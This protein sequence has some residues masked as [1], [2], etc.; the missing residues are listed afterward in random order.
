[1]QGGRCLA[2][3]GAPFGIKPGSPTASVCHVSGCKPAPLIHGTSKE[4]WGQLGLKKV[5][6]SSG[7]R[8]R[9]A[10]HAQERLLHSNAATQR[11]VC[12]LFL[13]ADLPPSPI[14]YPRRCVHSGALR[15]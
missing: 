11:P 7:C 3:A 5:T 13:G 1:V 2:R 8:A 10:R 14:E 15:K 12:A 4:M 9:G 6:R